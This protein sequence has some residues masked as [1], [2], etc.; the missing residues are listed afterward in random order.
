MLMAVLVA[1]G[2]MQLAWM[3]GLAALILLEKVSPIGER[4]AVVASSAFLLL[5]VVLLFHPATVSYLT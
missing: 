1:F 3:A 2:T 4:V 5:G